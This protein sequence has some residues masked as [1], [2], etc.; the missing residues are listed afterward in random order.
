MDRR[1]LSYA[2]Q[3]DSPIEMG[4]RHD[5][6]TARFSHYSLYVITRINCRNIGHFPVSGIVDL[7]RRPIV[8]V[9]GGAGKSLTQVSDSSRVCFPV[10]DSPDGQ[11]DSSPTPLPNR[12]Y[13]AGRAD[14]VVPGSFDPRRSHESTKAPDSGA[15]FR[16][17]HLPWQSDVSEFSEAPSRD[18]QSLGSTSAA[19][20]LGVRWRS[21]ASVINVSNQFRNGSGPDHN[22]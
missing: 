20:C 17:W 15:T 3:S 5:F 10:I 18:S 1:E 16:R 6:E 22:Q 19:A 2:E 8:E 21:P 13:T 12:A 7:N 11:P 14:R 9:V 4:E